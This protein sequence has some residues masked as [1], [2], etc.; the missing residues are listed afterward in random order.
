[1]RDCRGEADIATWN[2]SVEVDLL[3]KMDVG[4]FCWVNGDST[5]A[6]GE[7]TSV[8]YGGISRG[9]TDGNGAR[10][11]ADIGSQRLLICF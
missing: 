3:W 9:D 4:S 10:K 2:V 1:M 6:I 7:L 8:Q 5:S 11:S